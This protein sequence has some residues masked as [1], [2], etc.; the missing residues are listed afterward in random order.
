MGHPA[1]NGGFRPQEIQR[2]KFQAVAAYTI[3]DHA[4]ALKN[5]DAR[6][7]IAT[8]GLSALTETVTHNAKALAVIGERVPA[9]ALTFRG[10]LRWLLT[11]Q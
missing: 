7:T 4:K 1:S 3:D 9:D 2:R 10:R 8:D 11:G 6:I 5:H